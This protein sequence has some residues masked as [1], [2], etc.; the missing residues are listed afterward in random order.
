MAKKEVQQEP[1]QEQVK[2]KKQPKKQKER[3]PSP[4]RKFQIIWEIWSWIKTIWTISMIS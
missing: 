2:D 1:M 3:V 4:I